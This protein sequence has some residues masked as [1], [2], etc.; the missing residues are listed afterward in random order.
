M[1]STLMGAVE[2]FFTQGLPLLGALMFVTVVLLPAI[3]I[4]LGLY[5]LIPLRL[6]RVPSLAAPAYRVMLAIGPWSQIDILVLGVLVAMGKLATQSGV[7]P[8]IGFLCLC[9]SLVSLIAAR[10]TLEPRVFWRHVEEVNPQ[11]HAAVAPACGVCDRPCPMPTCPRCGAQRL[12]DQRGSLSRTSALLIAAACLYFPANLLTMMSTTVFFQRQDDTIFSGVVYLWVTGSWPLALLVLFA[13][14]LVPV[15]KIL[16]LSMLVLAAR[17]RSP[18][19]RQ[20]RT[21]LY[22]FLE[23]VGRWSML[24]IYVASFLCALVQAQS[25]AKV[26]V[27]PAALAFGAVVVLTMLASMS[28]D[29]R[30]TWQ[31]RAETAHE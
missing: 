30:L 7:S 12:I 25:L 14:V 5:L 15:F 3:Q 22:R 26:E 2:I 13:S 23:L 16:A 19:R 28:F 27:G 1:T 17:K 18:W 21:R 31:A 29:P 9:G 20:G 4:G 11:A 6:G 8:G 10:A 24:D